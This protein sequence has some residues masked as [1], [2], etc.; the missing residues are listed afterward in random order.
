MSDKNIFGG[1]K[2]KKISGLVLITCMTIGVAFASAVSDDSSLRSLGAGTQSQS[3]SQAH[4]T[5]T[6]LTVS[7]K[8][9][10]LI[11][12]TITNRPAASNDNLEI[13]WTAPKQSLCIDST[14]PIKA[15]PNPRHDV[16]WAYRTLV[17]TYKGKT[18][19][20]SGTWSIEI[21]N[22]STGQTL[23]QQDYTVK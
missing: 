2:M 23:A 20:C 18:F 1:C 21:V 12:T 13:N 5:T 14:F 19:S 15:G 11:A 17:R 7:E 4:A 9:N 10:R 6:Q 3:S 22:N 8:G 16:F